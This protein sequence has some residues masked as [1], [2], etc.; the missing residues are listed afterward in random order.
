LF[1]L[2][3]HYSHGF[4]AG[5][6][7]DA[8]ILKELACLTTRNQAKDLILIGDARLI[9]WGFG[10]SRIKLHEEAVRHLHKPIFCNIQTLTYCIYFPQEDV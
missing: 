7:T 5:R 6:G 8:T 4:T 1:W 10:Y 2:D 9:G 3:V